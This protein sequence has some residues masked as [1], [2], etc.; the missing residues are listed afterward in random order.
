M[1]QRK[2]GAVLSYVNILALIL[3]GLLYTPL[4]LRL[5]GRSEYGLY[6]LIGS[7]VGYLSVLDMG[8]GNTIVR[9]ISINR[10]QGNE[11]REAELNTLFLLVYCGLGCLAAVIGTWIYF[12]LDNIFGASLTLG[13]MHRA[14][15]MTALLV[16]NISV[17]FPL[18]LF[19]AVMTVYERFIFLR[20]SNI[21]RVVINPLIV[22]PMLYLGY[23]SVMM[24]VV[25]TMLNLAC[26]LANAGYCFRYLHIQFRLGTYSGIFLWEI[27]VYS[28]FIFLNAIMDKIY[29]STGQFILG[30]VSGTQAVAVYAVAIQIILMYM[31]FSTA[32]SSVVFPKITRMVA[33]GADGNMLT[34]V[35]VKI[36]RLQYIVIVY[37]VIMFA[38]LGRD[39]LRLW[40]GNDYLGA[41]PIILLL[42]AGLFTPLIQNAG[43]SILQAENRNKFRMTV[44][45]LCAASSVF[46]S[47]P[48]AK[49]Y[50]GLGCAI[51]TG[52]SMA[53]STGFIMNWYYQ[54]KIGIHL[55]K[56]WGNI[57]RMTIGAVLFA[58]C[59]YGICHYLLSE[60]NWITLIAAAV[61]CTLLYV[62]IM[63]LFSF[64]AY[65]QGLC[66]NGLLRLGIKF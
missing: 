10:V 47:V 51:G 19:S 4:M 46:I 29:Y 43:I 2:A 40:A 24:V 60:I 42:M 28:F 55:G 17:S 36:G 38:L 11:T 6:A 64:N 57:L 25:S 35:M 9:Y 16:F 32:I 7:F 15:I 3:I 58:G 23:G 39:F 34:D 61:L 27:A 53:V 18:G 1:N 54:K 63:Y 22:L 14:R 56:F 8:L 62:P 66:K 49:I 45:I 20:V 59:A 52:L 31:Q 48:L 13:E 5:L 12:H 41:Y 21:L 26:L 33:G 30:I 44:Y 50:G 37:I 65:E